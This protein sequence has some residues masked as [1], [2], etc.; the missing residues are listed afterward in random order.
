M[1]PH[2]V[3]IEKS[4]KKVLAA[5]FEKEYF[6]GITNYIKTEKTA[7]KVIYPTGSLIFNAFE[8]TPFDKV[9]V[10]ILGQ[11]PYHGPGEAMGLCFSVPEKIRVPPSLRNIF[12]ELHQDLNIEIPTHGD[13]S[14]WADQ[15]V[16]LLNAF[17]TVEHK[18]ASSHSKIGWHHFTDAV[19]Q[20][21]S[22]QKENLV[23]LLWGNFAKSKKELIDSKKHLILESAHPSPLA[24]NLFFGNHHF[25]KCNQYLNDHGK[26]TINWQT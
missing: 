20:K 7:G 19:I 26:Q 2:K 12:K 5:E 11:D 23:F 14:K 10:V 17:L 22:D 15:G 8:K 21:L 6:Q 13:L 4:W 24:R 16:F 1:D 9:R 3:R 25:S 18:K